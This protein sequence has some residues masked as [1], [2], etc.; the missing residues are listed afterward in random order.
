MKTRMRMHENRNNMNSFYGGNDQYINVTT[1]TQSQL[2]NIVK[3]PLSL[4]LN[5][6]SNN[7]RLLGK[8]RAAVSSLILNTPDLN[9]L[10]M[11]TPDV[12]RFIASNVGPLQTLTPGCVTNNPLKVI[13][14]IIIFPLAF[15]QIEQK[16]I[17]TIN[18]CVLFVVFVGYAGARRIC[19]WFHR[20]LE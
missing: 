11:D 3:R 5:A 7:N 2:P 6:A 19:T 17:I 8:K 10:E 12:V 16:K 14:L 13:T 15:S 1:S 18:V 9:K 4:D 20:G